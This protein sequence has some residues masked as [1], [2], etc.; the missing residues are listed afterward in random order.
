MRDPL[1]RGRLCTLDGCSR[2]RGQDHRLGRAEYRSRRAGVGG[3]RSPTTSIRPIGVAGSPRNLCASRSLTPS[4]ISALPTSAL[5]PGPTTSHRLAFCSRAASSESVSFPNWGATSTGSPPRAGVSGARPNKR[6]GFDLQFRE[7]RAGDWY[8]SP[9]IYPPRSRDWKGPG[10][11][12][13]T[14]CSS[15]PKPWRCGRSRR[16]G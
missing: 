15:S 3:P 8:V 2:G 1:R 6:L 5:S 4:T 9:A 7:L 11:R 14:A 13:S 16:R 12:Y 10:H